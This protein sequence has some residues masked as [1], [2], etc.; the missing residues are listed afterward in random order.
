MLTHIKGKVSLKV[1]LLNLCDILS[2]FCENEFIWNGYEFTEF[3]AHMEKVWNVD[4]FF[5]DY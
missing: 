1:D 5:S 2:S 3:P 4:I